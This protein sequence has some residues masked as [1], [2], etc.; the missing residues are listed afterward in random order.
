MSFP[1]YSLQFNWNNLFFFSIF[2]GIYGYNITMSNELQVLASFT[3][4][5]LQIAS[6]YNSTLKNG[7]FID[8][9]VICWSTYQSSNQLTITM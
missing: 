8:L 7:K 1:F 6:E 9:W 2:P 4:S 3:L 5:Y